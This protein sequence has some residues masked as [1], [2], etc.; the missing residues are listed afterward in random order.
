MNILL[1]CWLFLF[2]FFAPSIHTAYTQ[3]VLLKFCSYFIF[4]HSIK[5]FAR[6]TFI[7]F[8]VITKINPTKTTRCQMELKLWRCIPVLVFQLDLIEFEPL[9]W[10]KRSKN[11][12][13]CKVIWNLKI[14]LV[15]YYTRAN[16]DLSK[17]KIYCIDPNIVHHVQKNYT[18]FSRINK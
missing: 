10:L 13:R 15:S 6:Q 12:I 14:C 3:F 4:V 8:Y 5:K 7:L 1:T 2:Y 18:S 11:S 17:E 16:S 9:C